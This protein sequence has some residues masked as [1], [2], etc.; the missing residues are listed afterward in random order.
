MKKAYDPQLMSFAYSLGRL[1]RLNERFHASVQ[2][3]SASLLGERK[4][5][6]E[7]HVVLSLLTSEGEVLSPT[8]LC[9]Y[10]LQTPSGMTKT[11]RRL[12]EAGLVAR[13]ESSDDARFSM[14]RLTPAGRRLAERL[15]QV[16]LAAYRE[17]FE[18]FPPAEFVAMVRMLRVVRKT[19]EQSLVT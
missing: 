17:A 2:A 18:A 10:T 8:Q 6:A 1:S 11:L 14:V 9:D 12:E 4:T 13:F 5:S 3:R 19:L 16:T 7:Y 15:M